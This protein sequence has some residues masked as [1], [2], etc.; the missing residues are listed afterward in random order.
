[1]P[2]FNQL[3]RLATFLVA[4][5]VSCP[6]GLRCR[7]PSVYVAARIRWVLM[8][9]V[10]W[11]TVLEAGTSWDRGGTG[12]NPDGLPLFNGTETITIGTGFRP[13]TTLPLDGNDGTLQAANNFVG[14]LSEK[15]LECAME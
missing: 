10:C 5:A 6:V 8:L 1:M 13:G 9:V 11:A 15:E 4:L 14:A 12:A 2:C 3:F 7:F